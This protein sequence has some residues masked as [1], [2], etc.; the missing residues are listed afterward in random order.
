[1]AKIIITLFRTGR[2]VKEDIDNFDNY[3]NESKKYLK[4]LILKD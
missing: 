2:K 1:M 4:E 3:F